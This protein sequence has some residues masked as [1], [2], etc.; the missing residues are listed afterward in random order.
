LVTLQICPANLRSNRLPPHFRGLRMS[1]QLPDALKD[2]LWWGLDRTFIDPAV[3]PKLNAYRA[4]L[5]L[6]PE[7]RIFSR[8]LNS[9]QRVVG[10]FPSWFA[11]P[12]PDW[13]PQAALTGF[14]FA[15]EPE[16]LPDDVQRFLNAGAPPVVFTF[17]SAL[18]PARRLF[19]MATAAC[20]SLGLRGVLLGHQASAVPAA[21]PASVR[22]F[23]YV[24]LRGLL[25]R[26]AALVHHGGIG[27]CALALEAGV[28]QLAMPLAFD[29]FDNA[30]R[31]SRL[32]VAAQLDWA[33]LTQRRFT[34]GLEALLASQA[35][36]AA[37]TKAAGFFADTH[38]ALTRTSELVEAAAVGQ[39]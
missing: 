26:T 38:A 39:A 7:R 35:H 12:Q 20:D 31:L 21:L 27:T 18:A 37:A 23:G 13:P 19:E 24:P 28:R 16:G 1:P 14:V 33:S 34:A 8:W 15:D 17:G 3:L 2:A 10:L 29:Q 22:Y 32:G 6:P 25:P 5:G 30:E 4:Q 36:G 11:P 9:P